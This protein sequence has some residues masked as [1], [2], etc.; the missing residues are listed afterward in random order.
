MFNGMQ[1]RKA[2]TEL[3]P[4]LRPRPQIRDTPSHNYLNPSKYEVVRPCL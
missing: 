1:A 4:V 3:E 2:C